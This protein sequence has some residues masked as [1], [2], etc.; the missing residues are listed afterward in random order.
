MKYTY[1]IVSTHGIKC[2][3]ATNKNH[4]IVSWNKYF[5]KIVAF[6]LKRGTITLTLDV[7]FTY[8]AGLSPHKDSVWQAHVH[9]LT[10]CLPFIAQFSRSCCLDRHVSFCI[11]QAKPKFN[12]LNIEGRGT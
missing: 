2:I 8:I 4:L 6:I 1:P 7:P 3:G 11:N 9:A 12:I 10:L 5:N